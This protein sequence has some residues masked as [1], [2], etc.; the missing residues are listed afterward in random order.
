MAT[1]DHLTSLSDDLQR[2]LELRWW[3]Y[4]H[5]YLVAKR[6]ELEAQQPAPPAQPEV[7]P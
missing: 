6:L 5:V 3:L 7:N 2:A 1:T 4:R